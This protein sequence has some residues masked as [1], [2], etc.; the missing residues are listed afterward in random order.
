M[1]RA[2]TYVRCATE[3]DAVPHVRRGGEGGAAAIVHLVRQGPG[4]QRQANELLCAVI[5]VDPGFPGTSRKRQPGLLSHGGKGGELAGLG[6][7]SLEV[8]EQG[9]PARDQ[10]CADGLPVGV[11]LMAPPLAEAGLLRAARALERELDVDANAP[12]K[13]V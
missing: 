6:K 12:A 10:S 1:V 9:G 11:Q 3:D 5:H 7:G 13:V 8:S 4:F 2:D